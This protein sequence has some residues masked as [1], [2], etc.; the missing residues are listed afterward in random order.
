VPV[1]GCSYL[2]EAALQLVIIEIASAAVAKTTSNVMPL[3]FT[4][5]VVAWNVA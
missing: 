5:L 2:A 3:V 1:W 4:A